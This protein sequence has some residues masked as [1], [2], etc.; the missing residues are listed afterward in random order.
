MWITADT[1]P[2]AAVFAAAT[3][4]VCDGFTPRY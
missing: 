2:D 3:G 1:E 4:G